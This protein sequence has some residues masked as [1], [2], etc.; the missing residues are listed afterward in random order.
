[1]LVRPHILAVSLALLAAGCLRCPDPFY[2]LTT[3][4]PVVRLPADESPHCF[5]GV[6]W[7]YYSGRLTAAAGQEFGVEI[8][9]F[10]VPPLPLFLGGERWVAHFAVIEVQGARFKYD[11][12]EVPGPQSAAALA[13]GGF[14]LHTPLVHMQGGNGLDL[15][16]AMFTDG[17]YSVSLE[18]LDQRGPVLHDGDGYVPFGSNGH[19]FYYSRPRMDASGTLDVA[20]ETLDVTGQIWFDRQWGRDLNNPHQ[21]WR[22]FSLRMK[23]GTDIMLYEFPGRGGMVAFGTFV[24]PSAPAFSLSAEEFDVVPTATWSSPATGIEYGVGWTI[25]LPGSNTV[26]TLSALVDDAELDTR[27]TT[28]EVYWE[29][30]CTVRSSM[31]PEAV[32]GYAYVEQV[33]GP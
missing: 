30:L 27:T 14:D 17:S 18:L 4:D 15:V 3:D 1:V 10:H 12:V 22:W 21:H 32:A 11:Q 19:S 26:L 7:W 24:P 28:R 9:I 23:D 31:D 29:G 5:G 25:E 20:G 2:E 13:G 33:K 16:E 6:E 8:V